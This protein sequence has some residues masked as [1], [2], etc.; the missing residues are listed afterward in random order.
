MMKNKSYIIYI[1]LGFCISLTMIL[2]LKDGYVKRYA[3]N[4]KRFLANE[5]QNT[6]QFREYVIT[7]KKLIDKVNHARVQ[8]TQRTI[9]RYKEAEVMYNNLKQLTMNVDEARKAMA[10]QYDLK[11]I[12]AYGIRLVRELGKENAKKFE[13]PDGDFYVVKVRRCDN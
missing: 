3:I 9:E 8:S 12:K 1:L 10:E 4:T 6:I 11:T 5:K 7:D 2:I 13:G